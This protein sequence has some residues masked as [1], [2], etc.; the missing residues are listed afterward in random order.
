MADIDVVKKGSRT[1]VWF[2]VLAVLALILWFLFASSG[3]RTV[4]AVEPFD[5]QITAESGAPVG[6][7][8][9]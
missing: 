8:A 7:V 4:G 9:A 1:W 3:P 2:L 5:S 6:A